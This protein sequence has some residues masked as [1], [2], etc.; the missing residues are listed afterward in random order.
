MSIEQN[1]GVTVLSAITIFLLMGYV[2][3]AITQSPEPAILFWAAI[4]FVNIIFLLVSYITHTKIALRP[5]FKKFII[6]F[7]PIVLSFS[8][9]LFF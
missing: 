7:T 1:Q 8:L 2:L 4:L 6:F 5:I 9:I 3:T